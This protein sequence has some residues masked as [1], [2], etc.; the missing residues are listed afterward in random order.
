MEPYRCE[1]PPNKWS[2]QFCLAE[3]SGPASV[4]FIT[5]DKQAKSLFSRE[6]RTE[7]IAFQCEGYFRFKRALKFDT[8]KMLLLY[9]IL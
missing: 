8:I 2:P 4:A 7:G 1:P 6:K 3:I 5:H 9:T